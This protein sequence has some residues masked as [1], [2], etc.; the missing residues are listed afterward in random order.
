VTQ[1][2]PDPHDAERL[3][4]NELLF[5]RYLDALNNAS[6]FAGPE[7]GPYAC[8]CCGD[9]TLSERGAYEI[10]P[11]C[12]WEDDGQDDADADTVRGGPNG[13]LS[14]TEARRQYRERR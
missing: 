9:V 11:T 5:A 12:W 8:P 3:R 13:S 14:L 2:G 6:V 1:S 7:G 10:C 4:R